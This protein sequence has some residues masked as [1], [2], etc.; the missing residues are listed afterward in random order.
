MAS[1]LFTW[2]ETKHVIKGVPFPGTPDPTACDIHA[3]T[4]DSR[5]VVPGALFI[6]IEGELTDGHRYLSQAVESRGAA[7]CV[8]KP[9]TPD[10]VA[11]CAA[12]DVPCLLVS[13]T[14]NAFQALSHRHRTRLSDLQVV[15][16]TGSCGKT[17][18]KEMIAAVLE[19]A[20]ADCVLKTEG[21]TNNHFGVPRNLLRLNV[22]HRFAVLELGSNHPGEIAAL[23]SLV[24]PDT[25]MVCNIGRAHLEFFGDTAGVAREKG[26]ILAGTVPEGTA[27]L[28]YEADHVETL[29]Q[30]AGERRIVTFGESPEADVSMLYLGRQ[31]SQFAVQLTIKATAEER[32]FRWGLG[33]RHQAMNAAGAAA[34]GLALDLPLSTI[35]EGL[36]QTRLPGMRM[37]VQEVGG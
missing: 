21:N 15:G 1:P 5:S 25:G 18:S 3:V 24:S 10:I 13:D 16:I 14:L 17:S 27:V 4:D 8:S 29:R 6:A 20:F 19:G 23:T 28:P 34:V 30:K 37:S 12:F 31:D 33:G 32:Q 35:T 22:N 7:I 11:K 26:D 9:P 2:S 36:R